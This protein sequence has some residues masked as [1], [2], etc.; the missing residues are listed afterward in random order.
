M[1]HLGSGRLWTQL[2]QGQPRLPWSLLQAPCR[3]LQHLGEVAMISPGAEGICEEAGR[4]LAGPDSLPLPSKDPLA[5][6]KPAALGLQ[7]I[8]VRDLGGMSPAPAHACLQL[9][10][11]PGKS[12][13]GQSCSLSS[14]LLCTSEHHWF[15]CLC[16]IHHFLLMKSSRRF[17]SGCPMAAV[18]HGRTHCPVGC[19]ISW[20]PEISNLFHG[21][22]SPSAISE[23]EEPVHESTMKEGRGQLVCTNT[24][25]VSS[26]SGAYP[27]LSGEL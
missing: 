16:D 20:C 9:S 13:P 17:S 26:S 21:L 5:C 14:Q 24:F 15:M 11:S 22:T 2:L 3:C 12:V 4:A 8:K 27:G 7:G 6:S 25:P 18:P 19:L 10:P 1:Q 23:Q